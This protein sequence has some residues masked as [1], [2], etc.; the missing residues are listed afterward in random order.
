M[1]EP[2]EATLDDVPE[3]DELSPLPPW[4]WDELSAEDHEATWREFS[5]WVGW[6]EQEY[7]TWVRLPPCWPLHEALR[8]ELAMFWYWHGDV[9]TVVDDPVT[10]IAW[11]NDLRQ[12]ALAWQQLADCDHEEPIRYH[13]QLAEQR[14]VRHERFLGQA[15]TRDGGVGR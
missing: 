11:H 9:M 3:P 13:R 8:A 4:V 5:A 12:S 10:G 15:I 6:L 1:T 7:G 14:R 2:D